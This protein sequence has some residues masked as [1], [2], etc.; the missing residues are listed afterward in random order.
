MNVAVKVT[1]AGLVRTLRALAHDLADRAE[2][3]YRSN[4]RRT[5]DGPARQA[6]L[7]QR[8]KELVDDRARR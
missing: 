1:V 6:R 5:E 8:A 7:P 2:Q 4:R 3:D